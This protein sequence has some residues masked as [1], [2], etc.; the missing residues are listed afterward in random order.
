MQRLLDALYLVS[1][2]LSKLRP[3]LEADGMPLSGMECDAEEDHIVDHG[4]GRRT[5]QR[6][7]ESGGL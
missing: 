5:A 4:N 6:V 2:A 3:L 7:C 1:S